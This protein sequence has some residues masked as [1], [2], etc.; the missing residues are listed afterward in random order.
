MILTGAS[1]KFA[2]AGHASRPVLSINRGFSA[3]VTIESDVSPEDLVFLAA[4]DDDPFARYEA[5]QSLIV[6]HLVA[7]ASG[8]LDDGQRDAGRAAIGGAFKAI[9]TD[10]SLDDLMR[11]ELMILP[12]ST[13]LAERLEVADPG[14]I[15]AAREGLKLDEGAK[16][17]K[18]N[19]LYKEQFA[20]L[21]SF[22]K[23]TL[24]GKVD[25]VSVS[26]HLVKSP[27]VV[28]TADY[29]WTAQMEKVCCARTGGKRQGRRRGVKALGAAR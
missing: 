25:K 7:D 4:H 26:K 22:I 19:D 24:G 21:I 5:M 15:H 10:P 12:S 2:F 23:A 16:E 27:V 29:G 18:L 8:Q 11:G 3:P 14:L 13:Y 17:K 6:Q 9:V 28:T 1:Q 20:P